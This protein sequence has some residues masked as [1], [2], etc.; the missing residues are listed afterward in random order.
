MKN[1]F[2]ERPRTFCALGGALLASEA[3]PDTVP[4]LHASVGCGGSI[5]WNPGWRD[6][7]ILE[8]GY[9]GG[10]AVPSSNVQEKDIVFGGSR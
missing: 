7:D 8:P 6:P 10:M 5:Y 1:G 9:C 2:I 3:L 4:I